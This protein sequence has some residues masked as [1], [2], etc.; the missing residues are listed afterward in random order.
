MIGAGANIR[1]GVSIG[2]GSVVGMGSVVLKDVLPS[3][4]VVGVPAKVIKRSWSE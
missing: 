1:N 2:S 3:T 4:T